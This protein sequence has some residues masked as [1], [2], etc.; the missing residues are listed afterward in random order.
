[1]ILNV[2][3]DEQ[4]YPIE[5]PDHIIKEDEAFF[6]RMDQDMDQGWQ[7]SREWVDNPDQT[8]RCQIVADKLFTAINQENETMVKLMVG[9]ILSRM[10]EVKTIHIDTHGEMLETELFYS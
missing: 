9:Y 10:P 2:T 1:M 3:L 5:V 8:Q 6:A 4:N 7:M